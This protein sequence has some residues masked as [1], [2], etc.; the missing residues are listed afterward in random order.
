MQ[1]DDTLGADGLRRFGAVNAIHGAAE[2]HRPGAERIAGAAG[3]VARQSGLARDH[4][5][6]RGPIRPLGLLGH[7]LQARP[8]EAV[9]A[10]A[11]AVADRLT[12]AGT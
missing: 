4:F 11:Y 7:R 8:G 10:D 12:A 2:I 1:P 6:G 9:A 5:R 3:Q